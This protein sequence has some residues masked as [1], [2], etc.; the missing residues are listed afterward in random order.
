MA[1]FREIEKQFFPLQKI[2]DVI[3]L[4]KHELKDDEPNLTLLSIV[5]W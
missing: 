2:Q 1:G 4:F 5:L 3:D